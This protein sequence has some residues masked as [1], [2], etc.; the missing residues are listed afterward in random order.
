[1]KILVIGNFMMDLVVRTPREFRIMVKRSLV[2]IFF[3]AQVGK[4]RTK[5]SRLLGLGQM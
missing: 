2:R 5:L 1:M 4:M 3:A